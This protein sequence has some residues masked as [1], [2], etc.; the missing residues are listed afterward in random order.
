MI[1][2]PHPQNNARR[3][4][5][6][7]PSPGHD[8]Q[9]GSSRPLRQ[10]PFS[11][12]TATVCPVKPVCRLSWGRILLVWMTAAYPI[13]P[14]FSL[15]EATGEKA[16]GSILGGIVGGQDIRHETAHIAGWRTRSVARRERTIVAREIIVCTDPARAGN[17][18][19]CPSSVS[20]P[21]SCAS[22]RVVSK[23]FACRTHPAVRP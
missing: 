11:G 20:D 12:S 8:R 23:S 21:N 5:C 16:S 14:V 7:R 13:L 22:C 6:V 2:F 3:S 19:T 9:D 4:V 17:C 15:F 1:S 18:T 10:K